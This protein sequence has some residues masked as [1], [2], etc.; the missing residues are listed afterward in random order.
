MSSGVGRRGLGDATYRILEVGNEVVAVLV[1]LEA[2][3]RHLRTGNVLNDR[4]GPPECI[5]TWREE[6]T[7]FGF[8]RYSNSVS[9]PQVTPLFTFAEV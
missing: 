2:S 9:S 4:V 8:S 7:F 1:L 5:M 3:E 6:L